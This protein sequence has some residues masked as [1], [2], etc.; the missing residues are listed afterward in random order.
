LC[1]VFLLIAARGAG[2]FSVDGSRRRR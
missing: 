2:R 1:F